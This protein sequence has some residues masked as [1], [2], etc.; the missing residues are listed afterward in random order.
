[1]QLLFQREIV[2]DDTVVNDNDLSLTIAVRMR[3][4]FGGTPMCRP[5]GMADSVP[6]LQWVRPDHF[7]EV[8][9]FARRA[10]DQQ[11]GPSVHD[12]DARRVVAAIFKPA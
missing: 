9:E 3:I 1:M 12:R 10:S 4:L 6:A 5:A 11:F 7:L 8:S 2:L